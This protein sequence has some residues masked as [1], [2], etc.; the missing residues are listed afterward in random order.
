MSDFYGTSPADV[1]GALSRL[2]RGRA[3]E[4]GRSAGGRPL[5]AVRFG[6]EP[7]ERQANYSSAMAAGKPEA[8]FTEKHTRGLVIIA[9]EHGA[10]MEGTA[11]SLNLIA[12]MDS[13][14]DLMEKERP[15]LANAL[16]EVRLVIVPAANPDGRAR[17]PS[18]DPTVWSEDEMEKYRHG[19]W[20]DGSRITW[21][22][23]KAWHPMPLDRVGF[24]GGYFNDYGVNPAQAAFFGEDL[25]PETRAILR[26]VEAE[27]PG[28][29]LDLHS[30]G[31]GPFFIVGGKLIPPEL[32]A[33]QCYIDGVYRRMMV[34]G[35]RKP[36]AWTVRSKAEVVSI[37]S[38]YYHVS[39]AL[40]LVF[41]GA[42]GSQASNPQ[43]KEDIVESYMTAFAAV[44]WVGAREGFGG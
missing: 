15:E 23:C 31:S 3:F 36:K 5:R 35:G 37:Y 33:R 14:R 38:A 25:A 22:A 13:G 8:Y 10:E 43:T 24:L 27:A 2:T 7:P 20:A 6:E 18:N 30:C 1:D 34:E 44:A 41:E 29:V 17:I 4:F 28:C 32:T 9:C 19:L 16:S 26:L 42:N 11:A 39:G 21:P 12:L 40:P